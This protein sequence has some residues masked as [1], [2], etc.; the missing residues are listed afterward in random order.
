LKINILGA[1]HFLNKTDKFDFNYSFLKSKNKIMARTPGRIVLS[2]NP[3]ENLDVA[4]AI[5]SKHISVGAASPLLQLQGVEIG[6]I[7]STIEPAIALHETAENL[8][9]QMEDAYR[10][11][12]VYL[13]EIKKLTN[14]SIKILKAVYSDNPKKLGEWGINVD[15]S[16]QNRKKKTKEAE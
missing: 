16:V 6:L 1:V 12:D 8:K 14:K 10:Q 4:R 5:F 15:D 3:K 9:R 13:T 2:K 11:R 7:S